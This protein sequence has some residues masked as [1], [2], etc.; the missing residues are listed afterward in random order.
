MT[1]V[2]ALP[3]RSGLGSGRGWD[4]PARPGPGRR[5]IAAGIDRRDRLG[6]RGRGK[7]RSVD[8]RVVHLRRTH[9]VVA[10]GWRR[11]AQSWIRVGRR[12]VSPAE[13]HDSAHG[14]RA[15]WR[16]ARAGDSGR[17]EWRLAS[18]RGS[19]RRPVEV[20]VGERAGWD[21]PAVGAGAAN[22]RSWDRPTGQTGAAWSGRG[23]A[24]D[25]RADPQAGARRRADAEHLG[26]PRHHNR[27]EL[28]CPRLNPPAA[29]PL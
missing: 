22:D 4:R 1:P 5:T 6:R 13:I 2:E 14:R 11:L 17:P 21:R 20:G 7:E 18:G 19:G 16:T 12:G 3:A 26:P 10:N 28:T 25:R 8:R 29:G 23:G 24:V 9:R 15:D 27:P